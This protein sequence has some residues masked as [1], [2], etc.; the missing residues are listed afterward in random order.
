M[1]AAVP[2]NMYTRY[3]GSGEG[4]IDDL[5]ISTQPGGREVDVSWAEE[6]ED[7]RNEDGRGDIRVRPKIR[8]SSK[9]GEGDGEGEKG[10]DEEGDASR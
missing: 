8:W 2:V 6:E 5:M 7:L 1:A 10:R 3:E 4:F 9:G